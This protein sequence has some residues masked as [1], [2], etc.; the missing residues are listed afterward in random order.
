MCFRSEVTICNGK[1]WWCLNA[2]KVQ[3][4][5]RKLETVL[6]SDRAG[7][8]FRGCVDW[9]HWFPTI[10]QKL[11]SQGNLYFSATCQEQKSIFIRSI[12]AL[13]SCNWRGRQK[14]KQNHLYNQYRCW[15]DQH[16]TWYLRGPVQSPHQDIPL[17]STIYCPAKTKK[18]RRKLPKK[19]KKRGGRNILNNLKAFST[20]I[21]ELENFINT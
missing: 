21:L 1:Q 16:P 10:Q 15:G 14:C 5:F 17:L 8:T 12:L 11:A 6:R 2:T 9:I 13:F 18:R 3:T 4:S 19:K 20:V 7:N